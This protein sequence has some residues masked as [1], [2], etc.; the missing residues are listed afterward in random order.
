MLTS[1]E[2][3]GVSPI[4]SSTIDKG[5]PLKGLKNEEIHSAYTCRG[6]HLFGLSAGGLLG[7]IAKW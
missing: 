4:R 1:S 2:A 5:Y 3:Y 7:A 6:S